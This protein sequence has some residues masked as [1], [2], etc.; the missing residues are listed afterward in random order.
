MKYEDIIVSCGTGMSKAFYGWIKDSFDMKFAAHDG[1]LAIGN[2]GGPT[3]RLAFTN[4]LLSEVG[5]PALEASSKDV[6]KMTI[7]FSPEI[8][9][10]SRTGGTSSSL[11]AVQKRWLT[12][13][14]KLEIDGLDA[15]RVNKIDAFTVKPVS[16][17]DNP[18][19]AIEPAHLEVPDLVVGLPEASSDSW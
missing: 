13:N 14:F 2:L 11:P 4:A 16:A 5:L 15:T 8:T 7:K 9:R 10:F 1:E 19:A 18:G 17:S 6:A 3:S 12:S